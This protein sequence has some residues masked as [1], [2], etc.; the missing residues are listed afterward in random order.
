MDRLNGRKIIVTGGASG[1][2]AATV[3]LFRQEGA[4]VAVLDHGEAEAAVVAKACGAA[5]LSGARRMFRAYC[6]DL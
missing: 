6:G 4:A 3:R 2:G 1:I 5:E